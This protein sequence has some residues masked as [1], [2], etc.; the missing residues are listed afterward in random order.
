MIHYPRLAKQMGL[1]F[2]GTFFGWGVG[3]APKMMVIAKVLKELGFQKVV[4]ILD[5]NCTQLSNELKEKFPDYSF[6]TIPANDIRTKK[7]SPARPEI[8]GLTDERGNIRSEYS[9]CFKKLVQKI[10]SIVAPQLT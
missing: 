9:D 10:N 6:F 2:Q 8:I 5:G 7:V 4:G 1:E 3:G